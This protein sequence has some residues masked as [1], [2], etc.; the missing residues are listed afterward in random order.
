MFTHMCKS[1]IQARSPEEKSP[2]VGSLPSCNSSGFSRSQHYVNFTHFVVAETVFV[3]LGENFASP[4]FIIPSQL[5]IT[6][7]FNKV[8]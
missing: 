1:L 2:I 3:L 6:A 5:Y 8:I 4:K 7:L